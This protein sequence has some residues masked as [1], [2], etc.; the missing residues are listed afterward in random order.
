MENSEVQIIKITL[1]TLANSVQISMIDTKEVDL[2][3]GKLREYV[4]SIFKDDCS[5]ADSSAQVESFRSIDP[6]KALKRLA[7]LRRVNGIDLDRPHSQFGSIYCGLQLALLSASYFVPGC[8]VWRESGGVHLAALELKS[9]E[10]KIH[11]DDRKSKSLTT[12]AIGYY[13]DIIFNISY[14][15]PMNILMN[16]ELETNN[17][18]VIIEPY[19]V[20]RCALDFY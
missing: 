1:R 19:L 14:A 18:L 4:R 5:N 15:D 16:E 9:L 8:I 3:V 17:F 7:Q 13:F 11:A 2:I 10:F 20:S 12:Q 6:L